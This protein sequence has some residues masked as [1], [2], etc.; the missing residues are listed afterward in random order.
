[1]NPTP[2]ATSRSSHT[3]VPPPMPTTTSTYLSIPSTVSPDECCLVSTRAKPFPP[4]SHLKASSCVKPSS[5][6]TRG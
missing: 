1:M 3:P 2:I 4:P 6:H 5:P